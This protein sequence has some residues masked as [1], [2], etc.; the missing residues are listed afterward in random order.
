MWP[1]APRNAK[2][3]PQGT[4]FFWHQLMKSW[5][6]SQAADFKFPKQ[7]FSVYTPDV[8]DLY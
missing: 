3:T 8:K 4:A 2:N 6:P 5:V 1:E 7:P